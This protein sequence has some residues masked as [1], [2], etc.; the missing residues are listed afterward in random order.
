MNGITEILADLIDMQEFSKDNNEIKYLLTLIDIF[1]RFVWIVPLRRK[2]GQEVANSF[3]M[4]LK[5]RRPSKMWADKGREFYNNDIQQLVE[6]YSTENEEK[7]CVIER[8]NRTIMEQLYKY[9]SANNTI[10][11]VD[12]LDLLVDQYNNAI[13]SSIEA[14]RKE[15]E[16]KVWR[17]VYL[18]LGGKTMT[19]KFSVGDSVRIIKKKKTFDNGYTQI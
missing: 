10:K 15:N 2:S 5:E 13:H 3:S 6:L 9:F 14:S 18:E 19:P 12:V 16:N 1:P 11:C 7:S 4:I 8:F 17:N